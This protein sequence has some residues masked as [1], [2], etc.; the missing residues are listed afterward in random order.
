MSPNRFAL[1]AR[2][3][4]WTSYLRELWRDSLDV[5]MR[6]RPPLMPPRRL[7]WYVGGQFEQVGELYAGFFRD[8]A[9]LRPD[10]AVLDIGCGVG[11]LAAPLTSYLGPSARY[12][13]F[14][15]IERG[16]VW[17]RRHITARYPNF[18]F[19][20]ADVYNRFYNPHGRY[21]ASEYRFP[22]PDASFDFAFAT[23]LF[24]HMLPDDSENYLREAGR[25]L[26]PGG[27]CVATF[28]LLDDETERAIA[29][30]RTTPDFGHQGVGYRTVSLAEPE[31]A[32]AYP[33]EWV[34]DL[35]DRASLEIREIVRGRWR[36]V[37]SEYGQDIV[38]SQRLADAPPTQG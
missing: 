19:Q 11:R 36:G 30:G 15:I 29:A 5:A 9:G 6:R 33:V 4:K 25:V 16:I 28:F 10:D 23:S 37:G 12:E 31:Q 27:T 3:H 18:R 38:V 34:T 22:Y 17:C 21:P 20:V 24:T 14:D 35:H 1:P 13:G 8:R 26:R 7:Q 2:A 32:I